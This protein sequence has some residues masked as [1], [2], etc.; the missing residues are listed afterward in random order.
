LGKSLRLWYMVGM[1]AGESL[2]IS[3]PLKTEFYDRHER[4]AY[5]RAIET[6]KRIVDSPEV[7]AHARVFV[8]RHF[9]TDPHQR[10]AFETWRK[11][12][13]RP[14]EAIA[15]A[16]LEDSDAGAELRGS[17]PVFFVIGGETRLELLR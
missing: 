2:V 17:A 14:P 6:A 1:S 16:L 15:C 5:L 13:E 10:V 3:L 12:L 8:D 11:L 7:I 4:R 9:R